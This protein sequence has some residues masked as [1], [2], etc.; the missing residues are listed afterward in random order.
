MTDETNPTPGPWSATPDGFIAA[1]SDQ[2]ND[3]YYIASTHGYDERLANAR[4]IASAPDLLAAL[5]L[6]REMGWPE[7]RQTEVPD[8]LLD[9]V[10]AAI[11][12]AEGRSE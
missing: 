5:K 2:M 7:T 3:G 1:P 9:V 6:V 12:K 4:L 10:D 11:S 8:R